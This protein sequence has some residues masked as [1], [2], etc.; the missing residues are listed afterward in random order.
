MKF[1]SEHSLRANYDI[2]LNRIFFTSKFRT[3]FSQKFMLCPSGLTMGANVE[4]DAPTS[5][6]VA[7]KKYG[8]ESL[9]N[10]GFEFSDLSDYVSNYYAEEKLTPEMKDFCV[11]YIKVVDEG[12]YETVKRCGVK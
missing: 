10:N 9:S 3:A 7:V 11:E 2:A 5:F 1:Y 8:Y 4:G 12:L 6:Y